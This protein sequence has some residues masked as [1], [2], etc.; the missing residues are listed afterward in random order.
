MSDVDTQDFYLDCDHAHLHDAGWHDRD[1]TVHQQARARARPREPA[2]AV[3]G[4]AGGGLAAPPPARARVFR[5]TPGGWQEGSCKL[6][7]LAIDGCSRVPQPGI[8]A[9]RPWN[10][11]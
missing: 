4:D 10:S 7:S 8:A 3:K 11:T 9:E 1:D 2:L 5:K 6:P